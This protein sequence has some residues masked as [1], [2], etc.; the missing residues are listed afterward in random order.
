MDTP[1]A[2]NAILGHLSHWLIG[3]GRA[4]AAKVV[5]PVNKIGMKNSI[6]CRTA[7]FADS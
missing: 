4:T 5:T 2:G 1:Q 3:K 7:V 6:F